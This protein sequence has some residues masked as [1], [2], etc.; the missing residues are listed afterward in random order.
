[1]R[2]KLTALFMAGILLCIS[3]CQSRKVSTNSENITPTLPIVNIAEEKQATA[4]K[5]PTQV[6]TETPT[7]FVPEKEQPK[8]TVTELSEAWEERYSEITLSK[9]LKK[10]G[11]DTPVMTQRLGADPYAMVY[12]GRV[13]LYMTGDVLEYTN[14]KVSSN[15]YS[16]INTIAVVSSDDLV[17]WTDHGTIYA[18]GRNGASKWGNNSWAPAACYKEIDGKTKFFLYF[19]NNGNGIGVL[20]ADSPTGPFTDPLGCA[21]I[22]RKTPNCGNVEWLFD[23]AVLIDDDGSAY[24]YFGGGV[25]AGKDAHPQT[26]RVVKLG[27]DMISI[28]GEPQT[29]DAPFLFEDSGINKIGDTYYYSYCTNW[30]VESHKDE[31]A[32]YGFR[33]AEIAYMT[34]KSPMGPFTYAG[35]VLKN[36]GVYYGCY[37]NNHHCMFSYQGEWYITYHTQML[38]AAMNISGGYRA[39]GITKINVREDGTVERV[40]KANRQ[41]LTQ[42]KPLNPYFQTEAETMATMGGLNTVQEGLQS[43][44][45]GSGN[46]A[47]SEIHTGDW[48]A[49]YGVDFGDEGAQSFSAN[50]RAKEGVTGII[51]LRL[52]RTDGEVIGYL[53]IGEHMDNEY[54]E[55]S[56]KLL[57]KVCGE[58]DLVMVFAGEGYFVDSWRFD[59]E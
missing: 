49:L 35:V 18:A 38:E 52:D 30:N 45:C 31:A 55:S 14:K 53:Q 48:L 43:I 32:E 37:G 56:A 10:M 58:H 3:G 44:N 11:Y 5:E 7:P 50:V 41:M 17:N 8:M 26:A 21:L 29:I 4:T 24:L 51:Q 2:R 40:E 34:S 16:R 46:M 36:P 23:P 42:K 47:L 20:T 12:D 25:P 1:M 19:A 27:S 15:T 28:E 57:R 22:S 33:N 13:Y 54:H 6:P 9:T 39:T 59:H